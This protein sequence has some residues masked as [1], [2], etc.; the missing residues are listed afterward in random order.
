MA[1]APS[2][3]RHISDTAL[4]AA[5]FRARENDREDALFRDPF[6]ARLAGAR[7]FEI[8]S[9]LSTESH[10]ISWITRTFLFDRLIAAETAR[11]VD[12][13]VNLG[14]G[15]DTRP[16]RMSLPA[17]L[18]WVEA[19]APEIIAYKEDLL[20]REK[21]SCR[22]ERIGLD[23]TDANS[24]RAFLAAFAKKGRNILVVT[25]GVLIYLKSGEVAGLATEL[26]A[27]HSFRS[28][29]LELA[30]PHVLDTMQRTAGEPLRQA[31]ACFQ[32]APGEG[33]SFFEPH[34]WHLVQTQSVLKAAVAL[35][36]TPI[37][38]KLSPLIPDL[39]LHGQN[40]VPWIGV[41]QFRRQ[42]QDAMAPIHYRRSDIPRLES[43][44]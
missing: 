31:G 7:G 22:I 9:T 36:R 43:C 8:A 35:G 11:G 3:V 15:L 37:D 29:I 18:L 13:V 25:E 26:A 39:P 33:P 34:G 24:R 44:G 14:A 16:Y 41:C 1:A 17:A 6:A 38:P 27:E 5:A 28:W 21:P 30:S 42:P 20:A 10:G 40:S 4:W 32:F 23:L 2:L 12:V 19:D